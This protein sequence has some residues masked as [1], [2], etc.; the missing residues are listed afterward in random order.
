VVLARELGINRSAVTARIDRLVDSGVIKGFPIR[1]SNDVDRDAIRGV[2]TVVTE[3]TTDKTL[4]A[5]SAATPRSNDS[6][7]P[8]EHGTSSCRSAAETCPSSTSSLNASEPSPASATPRPNLL[9][10]SLTTA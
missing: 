5:K 7:P 9:F 10:N 1:L 8:L 6:T 2:T 3:P 4:C